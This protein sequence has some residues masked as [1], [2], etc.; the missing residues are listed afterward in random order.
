VKPEE[1]ERLQR[2]AFG[3]NAVVKDIINTEDVPENDLWAAVVEVGD[4]RFSYLEKKKPIKAPKSL[5]EAP[6]SLLEGKKVMPAVT[7][8]KAGISYNPI[9]HAWDELLEEEGKKEVEAERKRL[10]AAREEEERLAKIAAAQ[11]ERDDLQTEDDSIWEGIES[12]HE[13]AEWLKKRRPERKTQ[14]ERNKIKRRKEAERKA[15]Q[16]A[17]VKRL[18]QQA[19]QIS[20][21]ARDMRENDN[22]RALV[23]AQAAD[24]SDDEIDDRVLRRR[25]LGKAPY[26]TGFQ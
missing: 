25:K 13:C 9:F 22:S 23:P 19:Q 5:K 18:A 11:G 26:V 24:S 21:I 3:G 15:K 8:P 6:I 20:A 10:R 17:K 7:R 12:G 4:P 14:A 2:R 1:Y 16:L